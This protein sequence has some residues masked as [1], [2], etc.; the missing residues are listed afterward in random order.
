MFTCG[1]ILQCADILNPACPRS[2]TADTTATFEHR[3]K[4]LINDVKPVH[5][6]TYTISL[7]WTRQVFSSTLIIYFVELKYFLIIINTTKIPKGFKIIL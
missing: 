2:V 5:S 7:Q 1:I 4:S 3:S 6:F